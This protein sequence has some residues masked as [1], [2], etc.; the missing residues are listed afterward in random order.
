VQ[1]WNNTARSKYR[2]YAVVAE[3]TVDVCTEDEQVYLMK[4]LLD[5]ERHWMI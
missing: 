1:T 5:K 2:W 3:G 4:L